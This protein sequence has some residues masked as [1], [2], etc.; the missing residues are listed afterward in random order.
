RVQ[1]HEILTI[2][3]SYEACGRT[4]FRAEVFSVQITSRAS[5]ATEYQPQG[6]PYVSHYQIFR[7]GEAER[8][9]RCCSSGALPDCSCAARLHALPG[10]NVGCNGHRPAE[11]SSG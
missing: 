11:I 10:R 5:S 6:T 7:T 2:L 4:C 8:C 9:C 1:N 3:M